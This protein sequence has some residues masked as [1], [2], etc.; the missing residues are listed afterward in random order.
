LK[1]AY[2]VSFGS[3][4][5]HPAMSA[6]SLEAVPV[7]RGDDPVVFSVVLAALEAANIQS[8]QATRYDHLMKNA[9]PA[10]PSV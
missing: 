2:N 3:V 7:W 9:R 1:P 10:N 5:I 6:D 8:F 4:I